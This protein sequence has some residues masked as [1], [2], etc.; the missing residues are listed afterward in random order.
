LAILSTVSAFSYPSL[1]GLKTYGAYEMNYI[2]GMLK[3]LYKG[4]EAVMANLTSNMTLS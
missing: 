3:K 4:D 2:E 1:G